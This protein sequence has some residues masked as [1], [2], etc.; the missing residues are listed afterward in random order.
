MTREKEEGL[1]F[2]FVEIEMTKIYKMAFLL[3][4]NKQLVKELQD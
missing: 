3:S 4:E 2:R 1:C